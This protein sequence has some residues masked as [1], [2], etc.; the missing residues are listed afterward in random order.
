MKSFMFVKIL[1]LFLLFSITACDGLGGGGPPPPP[2]PPYQKFA[3]KVVVDGISVNVYNSAGVMYSQHLNIDLWYKGT[4]PDSKRCLNIAAHGAGEGKWIFDMS[5]PDY[6]F[7]D[8][9]YVDAATDVCDVVTFDMPG[10]G[11]SYA[12]PQD[13]DGMMLS[14]PQAGSII[15]QLVEIFTG[16]FGGIGLG[17]S[18]KVFLTGHSV[19]SIAASLA[20][21]GDVDGLI[22]T[23]FVVT[24]HPLGNGLTPQEFM[25]YATTPFPKYSVEFWEKMAHY[26]PGLINL[27]GYANTSHEMSLGQLLAGFSVFM[28]PD[29]AGTKKITQ[30]VLLVSG[31][32]DAVYPGGFLTNDASIFYPNARSVN[33]IM[34][35]DTG[36]ATFVHKNSPEAINGIREWLKSHK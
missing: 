23:G 33:I 30:D 11:E 29:S 19:G 20:A 13:M 16:K 15:R 28:N 18:G 17:Y 12:M 35:V 24:P 25:A 27:G 21:N 3:Q 8:Y 4:A 32:Q 1:S 31:D 5:A 22:L 6:E 7:H 10:Q 14:G 9:S 36:H 2:T 26:K 34:P